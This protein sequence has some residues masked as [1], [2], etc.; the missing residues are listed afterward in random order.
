MVCEFSG[1][2]Q[3]KVQFFRDVRN[4]AELKSSANTDI[5]IIPHSTVCCCSSCSCYMHTTYQFT[6]IFDLDRNS[7][8]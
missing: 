5:Q 3:P 7:Y 8:N 4:K 6:E 2:P 1:N